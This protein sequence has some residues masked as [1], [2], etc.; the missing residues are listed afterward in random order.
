MQVV[1]TTFYTTCITPP[2]P[3]A[4][5]SNEIVTSATGSVTFTDNGST[6]NV[7]PL[8][9]ESDAEFNAPFAVGAHSVAASY[10]GDPSYNTSTAAAV[11]F[12]VAKATPAIA[13][14]SAVSGLGGTL[15][16]GQA[17]T[18]TIQVEN[19]ANGGNL[20]TY[21]VGG[22]VPVA[23]PTGSVTITGLPSGV[24][25]SA[26]L[27]GSIDAGTTFV[28]STATITAPSTT[29]AGTYTVT[30][31]YSGDANYNVATSTGT[32]TIGAAATTQPT[33]TTVTSSA[34]STSIT[35]GV[36]LTATVSAASGQAAPAGSVAFTTAQGGSTVALGVASLTAAT[37]NTS[38]ATF[39][40]DSQSL[41]PG[42]NP[43]TVVYLGSSTFQ[44]SSALITITSG[45]SFTLAGSAVTATAGTPATATITITPNGGF[46][47]GVALSCAVVSGPS[48]ATNT[49]TCSVSAPAA[50]TTSTT[51]VT[52]TLTINTTAPTTAAL[53][54]PLNR[55]FTLGGGATGAT[56]A[57]LLFFGLPARRRRWRS[58]LSLLVFAAIAGAVIGCGGG[59]STAPS[60]PTTPTGGT[61]SGTYTVNV[62]G[63]GSTTSAN[64]TNPSPVT[65]TVQV[66]V[67]VN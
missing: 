36:T 21:G 42:S 4:S 1:P 28:G 15:Q 12:T 26:V 9:A 50:I 3:P 8:N 16:T 19:T 37:A 49:P 18:F 11:A 45:P 13:L 31:T 25:T 67:T 35:A 55:I 46:V 20:S 27:A 51:N 65:Q 34:T 52:A 22:F 44:T 64:S 41:Q 7:A 53:D 59:S 62:T 30:I 58:L 5:C 56:L 33:T 10:P 39:T 6:L 40:V 24:P 63:T 43:I 60:T 66:A 32:V 38:T 29:P 23:A 61:T 47:G 14:T 48:G 57:A 54:N 17:N 2:K